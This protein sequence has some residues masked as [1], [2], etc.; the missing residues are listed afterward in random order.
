[1]RVLDLLLVLILQGSA[2][3]GLIGKKKHVEPDQTEVATFAA[4]C[5][6]YSSRSS[7]STTSTSTSGL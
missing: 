6:W 4:G 2:T 1:M 3:V 5:F 7:S